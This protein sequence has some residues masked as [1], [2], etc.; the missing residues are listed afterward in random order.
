MGQ[1]RTNGTLT[2]VTAQIDAL[3]EASVRLER[4][5]EEVRRFLVVPG[6]DIA[7]VT[8]PLPRGDVKPR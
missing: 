1:E 7:P 2:E 4:S 8:R 3:R 6:R 5:L